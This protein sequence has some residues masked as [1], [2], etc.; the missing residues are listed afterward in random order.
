MTAYKP[1]ATLE[2]HEVFNQP[3][4][5]E[6]ANLFAG[7]RLLSGLV[8]RAGAA[9]HAAHL[10]AF[11]ARVGSAEAAAL[12]AQANRHPPVLA[13]FDR[14]GRRLDE[15]EFHPAYHALMAMGL[16]AGVAARAWTHPQ[17]GHVAHAALLSLMS[18]AESGVTCPMSMTYAAVAALRHEP[19]LAEPW[20]SGALATGYDPRV[21]PA[22]RKRALTLGMAMTEKQGGSDVRAN[23][24][25][26]APAGDGLF[27]L[28][29]HKWFCSAPMSDAFLT[30]AYAQG[31]LTCFLVPRWRP[32]GERNAIEIQRLKDK[33]GDRANA[34]AEIE[35]RG[36]LAWRLGEEGR[37]VPT[38]IAMVNHTRLDCAV[39]AASLMRQSLSLAIHH[40]EGRTAFQRRL[41]AQPLMEQVLASLAVEVE[42]HMALTFR[43]A[44]ALDGAVAGDAGEAALARLLI[45]LAKYWV[46][47]RCPAVLAEAMEV[48]GGAGFIEE[49]PMPRLF[50]AS[51]LNAIWEGSGNVIALDLLRAFGRDAD[52]FARLREHLAPLRDLGPGAAALLARADPHRLAEE[53]HAR[54]LAE[55]LGVL[56][57][58]RALQAWGR[59][60][61][62][63]ALLAGREAQTFGAGPLCGNAR[64]ILEHAR[65]AEGAG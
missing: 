47:K 25:R 13:A 28:T 55:T 20:L 43:A 54:A 53:R 27:A 44:Q 22:E 16:E 35:Y 63:A 48:Q 4:P 5:L 14:Y 46:T 24:T 60:D 39:G 40:A 38:I 51:P 2:T 62:A 65:L 59:A 8:A 23:T 19:A 31:G 12:G 1:R 56:A 64:A 15:V 30:L 34:S 21:L 42:A 61:T 57:A 17:G 36:A 18:Q 41:V 58:A 32:D 26:A 37:G 10:T 52:A 9:A 33:L 29:G 50:R 3:A 45:P 49:G 6:D 11:G 7:D